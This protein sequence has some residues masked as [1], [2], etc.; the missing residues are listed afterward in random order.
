MSALQPNCRLEPA[1]PRRRFYA[2]AD[3]PARLSL[4]INS[5]EHD[6][7]FIPVVSEDILQM[8][9]CALTRLARVDGTQLPKVFVVAPLSGHF[10][11]LL[12][13]VVVGLLPTFQVFFTDWINARHVALER[14]PF[15]LEK[16]IS[17]IIDMIE[18]LG[19]GLNVAAL[20]QAALP[21][22]VATAY[23]S[24]KSKPAAPRTL[25]L[26]AAP[27]DSAANP[28]RV[29]R[30]IRARSLTWYELNVITQVPPPYRGQDRL[31]YPGSV[32]LLGL[33]AY[34]ARHVGEGGEL[35]G[36]MLNDDG[37]DRLRFPFLDLYSA[38]MDLPAEV[39]LDTIGHIY[40]ERSVWQGK[41][42]ARSQQV[43]F[44]AV[45]STA[46]MTVE[47]E[48]DDIA[49]P[50]QTRRAHDLCPSVPVDAR[51]QLLVSAC[52]HFSLFHGDIWRRRVLPEVRAFIDRFGEAGIG[53]SS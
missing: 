52:G 13:D 53:S 47:G 29:V 31:V 39:F 46:L 50:G 45:R 20:C 19:S 24:E 36:K 38:Q 37:E 5:I 1:V 3:Q 49:A 8:P 6:G 11:I 7:E 17:Y 4:E 27:V 51:C 15:D 23:L 34:L 2:G 35:L 25:V 43:D 12:R 48:D 40:Q 14:G 26:M 18:R 9:F 22:L 21:A 30:L 42:T 41:L 10:P 32:Q 33:W 16:N 28:T 44:A